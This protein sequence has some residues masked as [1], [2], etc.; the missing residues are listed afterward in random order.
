MAEAGNKA[1]DRANVY[2]VDGSRTPFL[3]S[4]CGKTTADSS[5]L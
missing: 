5:T 1:T 3:K 2:I 4:Q